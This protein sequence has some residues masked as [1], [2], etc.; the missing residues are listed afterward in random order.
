MLGRRDRDESCSV[1]VSWRLPSHWQAGPDHVLVMELLGTE[2]HNP[3]LAED[4]PYSDNKTHHLTIRREFS[5]ADQNRVIRVQ[6]NR[7]LPK[8]QDVSGVWVQVIDQD[9]ET[10]KHSQK[11]YIQEEED[12]DSSQDYQLLMRESQPLG[13]IDYYES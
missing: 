1:S 2:D 10:S 7:S 3:L 13:M 12:Y 4:N 11:V 6:I 5:T 9:Y 8:Y